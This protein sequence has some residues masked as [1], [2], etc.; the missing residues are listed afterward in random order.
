MSH[1]LLILQPRDSGAS[2]VDQVSLIAMLQALDFIDATIEFDGKTHY[3]P[4]EDFLQLMTFL[5]C[6]PVV[7]LGEPGLT[8]E[9]FCH[10]A[11]EGPTAQTRF[12]GG[13]NVKPPRCPA[14]GHR[15]AQWQELVREW[16]ADREGYRLSCP[17]C[18]SEHPVTALKWRQC[19]GFGRF[20]IQ[21]WGIFEGEAVPSDRLLDALQQHTGM[22][23]SYFYYQ[24]A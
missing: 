5:G 14:C 18:G 17:G 23:W 12:V 19:T 3:R 15:F 11:F 6:S 22:A 2:L 10:V 7:A 24:T 16:E 9:D 21:V 1:N 4:G 8:G 13:R 20:F